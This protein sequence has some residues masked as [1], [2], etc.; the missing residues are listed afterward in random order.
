LQLSI[1]MVFD[2]GDVLDDAGVNN[3]NNNDDGT[4]FK[5]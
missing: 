5:L 3:N 2:E 4:D 1:S